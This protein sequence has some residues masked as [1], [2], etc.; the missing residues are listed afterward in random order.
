LLGRDVPQEVPYKLL[1]P[2]VLEQDGKQE[3]EVDDIQVQA[4]CMLELEQDDILVQAPCILELELDDILVQA[5][6]ILE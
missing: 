3:W 6:C 1:Q 4:P 5:P 2:Q